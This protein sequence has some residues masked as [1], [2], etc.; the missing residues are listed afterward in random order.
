[1]SKETQ[2]S[3]KIVQRSPTKLSF[4]P[5]QLETTFRKYH[6]ILRKNSLKKRQ[7]GISWNEVTFLS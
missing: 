3:L 7:E 5:P 6:E 4:K 2:V 1:M